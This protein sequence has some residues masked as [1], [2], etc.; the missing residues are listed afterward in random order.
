MDI[1]LGILVIT[2]LIILPFVGGLSFFF[3]GLNDLLN[4]DAEFDEK[5]KKHTAILDVV[6]GSMLLLF[7]NG[8]FWLILWP[9]FVIYYNLN[10]PTFSWLL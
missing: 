1:I 5:K 2:Q 10:L 6:L 9:I 8:F 7:F 3:G 4:Y